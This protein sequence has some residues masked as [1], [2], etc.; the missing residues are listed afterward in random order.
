M[1]ADRMDAGRRRACVVGA[2]IGGLAAAVALGR[3]GWEVEILERSA[4]IGES[5]SGLTVWSNGLRALDTIGLGAQVRARAMDET[6]AGIRNPKGEWLIRTDTSELVRRYGDVVMIPR[7][8]LFDILRAA[9][10]ELDVRVGVEVSGI[11]TYGDGVRILHDAG[12]SEADLVVGAD[13][14]HSAVRRW[15]CPRA[16]PPRYS[17]STA[18]RLITTRPVPSLHEG[19]Q[20]WGH[21]EQV[22]IIP[23][24]DGR[25]YLFGAAAVPAGQRNPGDEL[26][27]MRRR[28]GHWHEPIPTLLAAVGESDVLRHDIYE[29]PPIPAF[30]RGPVALL[31]DAAHAMTPNMGQGANQALEDA[32]TLAALLD[33][34]GRVEDALTEYNRIR[35]P[36]TQS[37]ARRSRSIGTVAQL[38]SVPAVVR[39]AALRV[40]PGN[41]LLRG[42]GAALS[43]EPPE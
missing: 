29:L 39:D 9:V 22:G 15:V 4:A 14:I 20:T 23:M 34:T 3:R 21:G 12:V 30:V 19:G 36:R 17:G 37:I 24:T 11:E 27:E 31:G 8:D 10:A 26:G 41:E 5:G 38:T 6:S 42:F 43:W 18:W 13:G 28:F 2:G 25:V 33:R 16:A 1:S 35:R 40:T 7:A 32:V